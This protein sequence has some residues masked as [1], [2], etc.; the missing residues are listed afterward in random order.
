MMNQET[1]HIRKLTTG[2]PGKG[3]TKI[4]AKDIDATIRS[5]ELTC[6]LGGEWSREI[7]FI[8]YFVCLSAACR[9][10]DRNNGKETDGLHR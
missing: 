5:G 8:A 2:Y 7:Y 9:R 4:V 3:G 1:I 6:L 10:R